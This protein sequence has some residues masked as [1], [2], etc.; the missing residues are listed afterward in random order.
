MYYIRVCEILRDNQQP[1]DPL[2]LIGNLGLVPANF[3]NPDF[4]VSFF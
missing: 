4:M 1:A 3:E 2:G